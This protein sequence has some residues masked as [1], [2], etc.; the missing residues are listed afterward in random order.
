MEFSNAFRVFN[1]RNYSLFFAGQLI[2][3]IG[4]WMQRTAVIWVVYS[5]TNSVM[6]VGITT[7]AEQFPSFIISPSGG[8]TADRYDR[9]KILMVTQ[10]TSALQAVLLT[11]LYATGH[12]AISYF[13][14]LSLILGIANAFDIPARQAMVND[15]VE[16]DE[17][18]PAAI[19]MNSSLNNFSRLAGPA[20]A[21][22]IL[23]EYGAAICFGSNAVSFLAV[24]IC[25]NLMKFPAYKPS[26]QRKNRW[27]DFREGLA[28]TRNNPEIAQTLLLAASVSLLV[29]TYNTLL[30]YFAK[31]I[32]MGNASTYGYINAAIGLGAFISTLF[33][34]SQKKGTD[35]KII[36]FY[37]LVILGIGL[38]IMA[39]VKILPIF[40]MSCFICGFGTMSVMPICNTIVQTESS[41]AMRGRVVGF[42]AMATLGTLPLGSLL[43]GAVS[44]VIE[45]R[46]CQLLQGL[47]CLVIVFLFYRFLKGDTATVKEIAPK[48]YS[49]SILDESE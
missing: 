44:K 24:I 12:H 10:V 2:S 21:G 14:I 11:V 13:L 36:L 25:L 6:M 17:D 47:I 43:V 19:A 46:Y 39:F 5:M 45:P 49:G 27:S 35:L 3:R 30:P 16:S 8:I 7:F 22:I 20:L 26:A 32:F 33:I 41:P 4:M 48:E 23:A 9:Y 37:N 18:L 34:A 28:Y 1:S 31:N 38:I 29:I 15:I 40:L 42:F